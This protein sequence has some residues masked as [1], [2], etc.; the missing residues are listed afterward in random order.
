M[1]IITAAKLSNILMTFFSRYNTYVLHVSVMTAHIHCQQAKSKLR[2]LNIGFSSLR[3]YALLLGNKYLIASMVLL[4][5]LVPFATNMVST[6]M[7]E[8][9]S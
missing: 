4:L 9:H 3:V 7:R 1:G 2:L 8:S 5:N 6:I